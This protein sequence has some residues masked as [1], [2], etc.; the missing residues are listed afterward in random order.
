MAGAPVPT[1][2]FARRQARTKSEQLRLAL[3]STVISARLEYLERFGHCAFGQPALQ[4][5]LAQPHPEPL[6]QA[7]GIANLADVAAQ[8]GNLTAE[9]L[10]DVDV[11]RRRRPAGDPYFTDGPRLEPL[12]SEQ[13]GW[14]RTCGLPASP[15]R[16]SLR[17][18]S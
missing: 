2:T 14:E 16:T 13:P 11:I 3:R 5:Q 9:C 1:V 15:P 10:R 17:S 18:R 7:F 12:V 4:S 6:L 8:G